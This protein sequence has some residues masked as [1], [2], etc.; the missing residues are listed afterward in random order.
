MDCTIIGCLID[1]D[2]FKYIY[3]ESIQFKE[4][5]FFEVAMQEIIENYAHF[6]LNNNGVGYIVYESRNNESALTDKSSDFKMYNNFCKIKVCNKGISFIN[7][8][9]ISKTIRYFYVYSKKD[10]VA[11]LQLADFVAYNILQSITRTKEQYTEFMKKIYD[12]FYNGMIDK[13][14]KDLRSYFGLKRLPYDFESI[15]CLEI[16]NAKIKKSYNSLKTERNSLIKKNNFLMDDKN[17][18]LEQNKK[19]KEEIKSLREKLE[20]KDLQ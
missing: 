9:I 15:H 10:D 2:K 8:E 18:L 13:A 19:L 1:L 20:M 16:E 6:L 12:R 17:K 7:Q 14:E 3:G 5:L 11:G 4:E